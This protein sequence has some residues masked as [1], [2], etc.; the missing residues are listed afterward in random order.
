MKNY[1]SLWAVFLLLFLRVQGLKAQ[2]QADSL[3]S[4]S[5]KWEYKNVGK[6]IVGR[7]A[8]FCSLYG[9]PQ[10]V[11]IVEI[12]PKEK[13]RAGIG[14]SRQMKR[15]S[16]LAREY[17]AVAAI[18]GSYFNMRAGNSAG[19]LKVD[20]AVIDSTEAYEFD[21]RVTG[22]VITRKG[23]LHIVP[24][25][26][27]I[28]R[29]YKKKVGTV[30]ASGPLMLLGG[31]YANWSSCQEGFINTKHPRSAIAITDKGKVLLITVDG[32]SR[33]HA[34]GMNIPELAHLIKVLGGRTALNLD[35]GGSTMLY[36]DGNI[37]NYPCDNR[38]FDH[39]G[40]RRIPNII[41][42]R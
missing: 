16:E 31:K 27:Q 29:G 4:L 38:K 14:I 30:L 24:W 3:A 42:F 34:I 41:Y 18:N 9:G 10:S 20:K 8:L 40:E 22:A 12:N 39:Q 15:I 36:L 37:I 33:E 2:G 17:K 6:G 35:G 21:L 28:E 32:R 13:R 1:L 23:K 7:S 19:F 11:S 25:T 5:A 26:R